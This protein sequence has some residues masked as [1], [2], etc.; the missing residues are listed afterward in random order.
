MTFR[1]LHSP[2]SAPRPSFELFLLK[3]SVFLVAA[4]L[5]KC[6]LA[7][8]AVFFLLFLLR[9]CRWWK[10]FPHFPSEC[11]QNP[12]VFFLV[13]PRLSYFS[14]GWKFTKLEICLL[15]ILLD[16]TK[17]DEGVGELIDDVTLEDEVGLENFLRPECVRVS[18]TNLNNWANFLHKVVYFLQ[19][20]D[21]GIT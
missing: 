11:P 3:D 1:K 4:Y 9:C 5:Q 20:I 2:F 18:W 12:R 8:F 15:L 7:D 19:I 21:N 6:F 13:L 14:S 17:I 16:M 10:W